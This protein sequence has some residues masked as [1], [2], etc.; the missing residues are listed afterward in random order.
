M[1]S[2]SQFTALEVNGEQL[3]LVDVLRLA[4]WQ[5]QLAFLQAAADLALIRQQAA[6]RGIEILGNE[7]QQAADDFRIARGL[8]EAEAVEAWLSANHLTFA[9]WELLLEDEVITR[10]LR[11]ALTDHQVE[12]HFAEHKLSFDAATISQIIVSDE[13]MAKELRA[14]SYEEGADFHHL[15][16]QY[17]ID[18][19]TR[20]ASGYVG[21][22]KRQDLA[23]E[24]SA[25]V[26]SA[27]AGRIVGPIKTDQG[28]HLIR[29]H[30]LHPATLDEATREQIKSLLFAEWLSEQRGK[31]RISTPL[32]EETGEDE[33]DEES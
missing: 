29:V 10:K 33:E 14:Q 25:A 12:Q 9:D 22:V 21:M 13:G 15:A 20:P 2:L 23:A 16:R 11:D 7:L 30:T 28:W 18:L 8:H 5:G 27:K 26:F 17:S 6:Q 4:K 31:A 19:V 1:T 32:L 3:S 24:A